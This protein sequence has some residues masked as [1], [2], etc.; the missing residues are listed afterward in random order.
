MR[1]AAFAVRAVYLLGA[2]RPP[3]VGVFMALSNAGWGAN[4]S[5]MCLVTACWCDGRPPSGIILS[6]LQTRLDLR[7]EPSRE[8]CRCHAPGLC[9]I[10]AVASR[11][12]VREPEVRPWRKTATF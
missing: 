2:F 4:V 5:G 8:G 7:P 6:V 3:L 9:S 10:A 11:A 1:C 12:G